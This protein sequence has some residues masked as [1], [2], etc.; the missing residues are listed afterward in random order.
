MLTWFSGNI[1]HTRKH[2]HTH[3]YTHTHTNTHTADLESWILVT[4]LFSYG[5]FEKSPIYTYSTA[6][7]IYWKKSPMYIRKSPIYIQSRILNARHTSLFIRLIWKEPYIHFRAPHIY[8]KESHIHSKG[9]HIYS[10]QNLQCPS[11][12]FFQT[13]HLKRA[14]YTPQSGPYIF[15]RAPCIFKRAPCIFKAE[16]W[17]LITCL[18]SNGSF[19]KKHCLIW[20]ESLSLS[21]HDFDL[22]S[23]ND[24][25]FHLF[26]RKWLWLSWAI[27]KSY[28]RDQHSSKEINIR[29]RPINVETNLQ[30]RPT[31]YLEMWSFDIYRF[32][33]M[34]IGLFR[35]ILVFFV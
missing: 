18:L 22:Y 4:R 5:S 3:T 24:F 30:K 14:P 2:T 32:R 31:S 35:W 8:S 10:K 28:K 21:I 29:K 12:I 13:A 34:N 17:M 33:L 19:E 20:K 26:G 16:S 15:K 9:P 1:S 11:Q 27:K 23:D 7:N 6:P 25:G